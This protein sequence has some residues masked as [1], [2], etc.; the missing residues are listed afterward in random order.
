MINSG[1]DPVSRR[2][3]RFEVFAGAGKRQDWPSRAKG[4]DCC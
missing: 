3:M 2:A 1:D 4:F